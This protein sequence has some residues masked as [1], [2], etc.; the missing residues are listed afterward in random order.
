MVDLFEQQ[1]AAAARR[2]KK[3]RN[4]VIWDTQTNLEW[5]VGPD[6]DTTWHEADTWVKCLTVAGGGWR[7]PS[8]DELRG[9]HQC[10]TGRGLLDS[11]FQTTGW[12]IWSGTIAGADYARYFCFDDGSE[13]QYYRDGSGEFRAFASRA[14]RR[15]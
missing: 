14:S 15:G 8:V 2:F 12:F 4:G 9:L 6:Q 7:L 1:A 10:G 3:S 5:Y 13:N 11:L